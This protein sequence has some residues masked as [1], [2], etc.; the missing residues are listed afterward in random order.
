[1][2]KNEF[3]VLLI[4]SSSLDEFIG[5]INNGDNPILVCTNYNSAREHD[6]LREHSRETCILFCDVS[7]LLV[8]TNNMPHFQYIILFPFN[9]V[10][11]PQHQL[12]LLSCQRFERV[13][14]MELLHLFTD[15]LLG[16]STPLL[17]CSLEQHLG[18]HY[19]NDSSTLV[20]VIINKLDRHHSSKCH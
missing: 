17:K 5:D 7:S 15:R 13:L 8:S 20:N 10:V 12:T 11:R 2:D 4:L 19:S 18:H 3:S 16:L 14:P 6:S 1:M 9:K